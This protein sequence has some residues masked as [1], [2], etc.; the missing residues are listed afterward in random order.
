[1]GT[2]NKNFE[3][4]LHDILEENCM[5]LKKIPEVTRYE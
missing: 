4:L 5:H 1:M 2:H 3:R